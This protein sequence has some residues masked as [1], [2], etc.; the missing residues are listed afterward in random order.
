MSFSYGN[1]KNTLVIFS[2]ISLFIVLI[3]S[4]AFTILIK[5]FSNKLEVPP[6]FKRWQLRF[7]SRF[8]FLFDIV[9]Y[10]ASIILAVVYPIIV[11]MM[12]ITIFAGSYNSINNYHELRSEEDGI[13]YSATD[14]RLKSKADESDIVGLSNLEFLIENDYAY[15]STTTF[16]TIGYGDITPRG[17]I[18][19][20]MTMLQM[21]ISNITGISIFALY[22]TLFYNYIGDKKVIRNTERY[23][24]DSDRSSIV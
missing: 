10:I 1:V 14:M 18:A 24:N 17:S 2:F 8:I 12:I 7:L 16:F 22:G 20:S 13:Y 15:F 6:I 9:Y 3:L 11:S 4:Q 23:M 21:I 5:A 19:K